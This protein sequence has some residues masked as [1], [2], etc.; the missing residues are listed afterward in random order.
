MTIVKPVAAF[1]SRRVPL[2]PGIW[3]PCFIYYG[4]LIYLISAGVM[5]ASRADRA[6]AILFFLT[7]RARRTQMGKVKLTP[8]FRSEETTFGFIAKP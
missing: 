8:A 7:R 3:Y 5:F 2:T 4:C 6:A 1:F